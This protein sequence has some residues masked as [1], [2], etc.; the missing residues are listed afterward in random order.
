[1][2]VN[3]EELEKQQ[4]NTIVIGCGNLLRRDDGVGPILIRHLWQHNLPSH[5]RIADA[6]TAGMDVIFQIR[7]AQKVILIDAARTGAEPGTIFKLPGESVETPPLE[8][9]NLHDFRWDHALVVGKWALKD[10]FPSDI[11]IYLIE[12]Q[13]TNF[14]EGLSPFV[15]QAMYRLIDELKL[16]LI[17][18]P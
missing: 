11:T 3:T 15:E 8:A 5:V 12:A 18:H 6:G 10:K 4:V 9:V 2:S 7:D 1:M 17:E 14:G 16:M 13:D